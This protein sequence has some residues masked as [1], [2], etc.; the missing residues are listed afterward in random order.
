MIRIHRNALVRLGA[1]REL[2]EG[3]EVVLASGT[4]SLSRRRREALERALGF[5]PQR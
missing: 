3:D 5:H 1:V 4:L 2:T